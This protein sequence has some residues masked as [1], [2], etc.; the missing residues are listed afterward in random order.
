[1]HF[2]I[3]YVNSIYLNDVMIKI[4]SQCKYLGH[5]VSD[6]LSDMIDIVVQVVC[7]LRAEWILLMCALGEWCIVS[8]KV[9]TTLKIIRL[10]VL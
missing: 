7:L 3:K 6:D 4:D 2:K 8:E 10:N 1:M 9:S 5:I